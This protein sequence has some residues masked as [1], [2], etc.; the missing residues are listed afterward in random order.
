MPKARRL[1][2]V[3]ASPVG[4]VSTFGGA[5]APTGWLLCDGTAISRTTYSDLF[6]VI[7]TT[8]GVGDGTTTFNLP[9]LNGRAVVGRD[10][11][12]T[13]FDTLGETGGVKS[14][15]LSTTQMPTHSHPNTL[16]SNTVASSGHIHYG[17]GQGGD[18]RTAIGATGSD[19]GSL[20]YVPSGPIS[21]GPGSIGAYTLFASFTTA[22]RGFNHYTPVYGYTSG[23]SGSQ[24]VGISN[25]N[26]GGTTA[27]NNL[28]P[29]VA[30]NYII[31]I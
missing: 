15:T 16:S 28:P 8:Y 27:V 17:T 5:T 6:T 3:Q 9:N 7:S 12:Q 1:A 23:P 21:P 13:E 20:G 19:A 26:A 25:A 10:S 2:K 29:Y 14:I 22:V 11:T 30:M 4:V 31:K 18:L 24:T